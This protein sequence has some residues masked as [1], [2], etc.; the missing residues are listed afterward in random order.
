MSVTKQLQKDCGG[1]W[2]Y[3][4]ATRKGEAVW[5]NQEG[6]IAMQVV[7]NGSIVIM[8]LGYKELR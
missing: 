4:K 7:K 3:V 8:P 1:Q 2:L 5:R 6:R